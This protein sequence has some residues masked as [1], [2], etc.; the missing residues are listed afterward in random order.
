M[1]S[2]LKKVLI[3]SSFLFLL[4][5]P[6][7]AIAAQE[8]TCGSVVEIGEYDINFIGVNIDVGRSGN[9]S[10]VFHNKKGEAGKASLD[11]A[12]LA[13]GNPKLDLCVIEDNYRIVQFKIKRQ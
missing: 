7:S 11:A 10:Y 13:L 4:S 9:G 6:H 2:I 8:W 3:S 1:K 5:L 12:F